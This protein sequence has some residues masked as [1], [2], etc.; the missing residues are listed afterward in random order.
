MS[1]YDF[2]LIFDPP[3]SLSMIINM[4]EPKS[5]ILEFGPAHGR[6]TKYLKENLNCIVDIVEIDDEAG[7]EASQY[8]NNAL[9]G[10]LDGNIENYVWLKKFNQAQYDY[11]IFADVLEHLHNPQEIVE[12]CKGV[13]KDSGSILISLPNIAHNSILLNLYFNKFKYTS[14]G[15]LDETHIRFF[16]LND[17]ETIYKDAGFALVEFHTIVSSA[18][19]TEQAEFFDADYKKIEKLFNGRNFGDVYQFVFKLQKSEYAGNTVISANDFNTQSIQIPV[20]LYFN[21]GEGYNQQEKETRIVEVVDR[22]KERFE[23]SKGIKSLRFD[24]SEGAPCNVRILNIITDAQVE[25]VQPINAINE[26][27][28]DRYFDEFLNAD[29]MYEIIGDFERATYIEIEAEINLI[30]TLNLIDR[31]YSIIEEVI[32]ER[33]NFMK[34]SKYMYGCIYLDLGNGYREEDK[35]IPEIHYHD[36]GTF[37]TEIRLGQEQTSYRLRF[38]P[39]NFP[40]HITLTNVN[41]NVSIEVNPVNLSDK[42]DLTDT[43]MHMS[44]SYEIL[45]KEDKP[46]NTM[47]IEGICRQ[48][49]QD[50]I[51]AYWNNR[52]D[53]YEMKFGKLRQELSDICNKNAIL[54]EQIG[55]LQNSNTALFER[56]KQADQQA[57]ELN[58]QLSQTRLEAAVHL[59]QVNE[60]YAV[61]VNSQ[62]WKMTAPLRVVLDSIKKTKIGNLGHK[63]IRSL[64]TYG[65]K[66]TL[67]KVKAHLRKTRMMKAEKLGDGIITFEQIVAITQQAYQGTVYLEYKIKELDRDNINGRRILLIG[68]ELS[69]TGAPVALHYFAKALQKNGDR[70]IIIA[71]SN[72]NMCGTSC[73]EGIP[74]IVINN[75][76]SVDFVSRYAPL[77]DLI[78]VNTIVGYPI[79]AMLT[80]ADLPVLW[81]IHEAEASYTDDTIKML[82]PILPYNI[83]IY[84]GGSYA[85]RLLLRYRPKYKTNQLLYCVADY[86]EEMHM[87]AIIELNLAEKKTIFAIVGTQEKRK[88]QDVVVDAILSMRR[89]QVERCLFVFVGKKCDP[90]TLYANG[91]PD[92]R[93]ERRSHADCSHRSAH[94]F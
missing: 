80:E 34:T 63:T 83:H 64:R 18:E 57:A 70:P 22:I 54:S 38:D 9:L 21:S 84:C 90:Y 33:S 32:G 81:W 71:P 1:K 89:E 20:T 61:V 55:Q 13:L 86:A 85:E 25:K 44:P 41:S 73:E 11:I 40:C 31:T 62:C 72:G 7:K 3:N 29:P 17:L 52:L 8:A 56:F 79:I 27:S 94:A 35:L 37:S 39:C 48:C 26:Y 43:F 82:P 58:A 87:K 60:A 47:T 10:D 69:L 15:L 36:D 2:E 67:Y 92:L 53:E 23:I 16:A 75:L 66:S 42:N 50:E 93:I 51:D 65:V 76:Y 12:K 49:G 28:E 74:V 5:K 19:N 68:H 78:V 91:L 14:V 6:M 4:I 30:S 77:F 24:P 46:I 45:S 59:R 88:G